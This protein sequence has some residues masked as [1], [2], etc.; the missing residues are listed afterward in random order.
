M[1][2]A[3][4][5]PNGAGDFRGARLRV[6]AGRLPLSDKWEFRMKIA[7]IGCPFRTT[8]GWYISSLR[9]SLERVGGAQ[10]KWVA[11]NCGCGDPIEVARNFQTD[12]VDY[13]EMRMFN[14][15]KDGSALK[16]AVRAPVRKASNYL[17]AARFAQRSADA[18]INHVQQTL[19]AYASAVVF[20]FLRRPS[21]AARVVTVHEL[22]PEQSEFSETNRTYNAADAVIVHDSWMKEKLVSYGV[23]ADRIHVVCCGTDLTP[24]ATAPRDGIAF[25]GGHNFNKGKGF[26]TLLQ[27]QRILKERNGG[28]A[29][30]IR[31]HGH[32]SAA[33]P[34]AMLALPAEYGAE[35]DVEWLNEL[36]MAEIAALY[37]R[38]QALVLPYSGSFGG[39]AVGFAA[40]N[41]L[42]VIATRFAGI[43]DH[44]GDLG[45]WIKG[46]DANE[47]A[48]RLQDVNGDAAKSQDLGARLRT[49]AEQRLGWDSIARDTLNVYEAARK[50]AAER[51]VRSATGHAA[52]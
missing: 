21:E 30:R 43:P 9:A 18:D 12:D 50:R 22:D 23:E 47:L 46:D 39:L 1:P 2:F 19:G 34:P 26:A 5:A 29:P 16:R 4:P 10:M 42:P 33:A 40:A 38:S 13:F 45:I 25:Y 8:Y 36:P 28:K 11:S 32:F 37:Q 3:S 41:S 51:L 49:H 52:T 6:W 44:L 31:V 35:N 14:Y 48:D 17:H 7:L 27:A 24:G 15:S 20:D